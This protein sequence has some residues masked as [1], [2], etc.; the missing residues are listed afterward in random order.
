MRIVIVTLFLLFSFTLAATADTGS[1][2]DDAYLNNNSYSCE[3][4][5]EMVYACQAPCVVE[6]CSAYCQYGPGSKRLACATAS[7]CEVF[8]ECLCAPEPISS[9]VVADDDDDSCGCGVT[10][11][12]ADASLMALMLAIGFIALVYSLRT[13]KQKR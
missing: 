1:P 4:L 7:S 9:V 12:P 3:D 5:C 8:N 2:D 13:T 10:N 6:E 11:R